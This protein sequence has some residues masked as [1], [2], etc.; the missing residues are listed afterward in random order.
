MNQAACRPNRTTKMKNLFLS[1]LVAS[2]TVACNST[3]YSTEDA[4]S[5]AAPAADCA[6][7]CATECATSCSDAQKAACSEAKTCPV[8]GETVEG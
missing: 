2:A 3:L 1:L 6:T 5:A 8:T 7:E 4:S